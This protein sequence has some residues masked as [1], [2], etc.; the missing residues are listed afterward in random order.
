MKLTLARLISSV[1]NPIVFLLPLPYL[2]VFRVTGDDGLALKW[3]FFSTAF[4]SV[5]GMF[6]LYAVHRK[7]FTDFDVSR[8]NQRHLLFAVVGAVSFVYLLGLI[9]LQG[10]PVLYIAIACIFI[11]IFVFSIINIFLKASIHLATF[12]AFVFILAVMY[13][14]RLL[15]LLLLMPVIAWSRVQTKRHSIDEATIGG[16]AGVLLTLGMYIVLKYVFH[17]SMP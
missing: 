17:L 2:L 12:S 11:S 4:I 13:G 5:V 15:L 7:I 10:P 9:F 3:F 14:E 16:F 8:R 6:V 1:T